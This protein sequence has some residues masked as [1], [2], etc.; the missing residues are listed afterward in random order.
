M[1]G[2]REGGQLAARRERLRVGDH[3]GEL[4]A[5]GAGGQ[6]VT[7]AL[8]LGQRQL[9][10]L[11]LRR[12]Q[13]GGPCTDRRGEHARAPRHARQRRLL[14]RRQQPVAHDPRATVVDLQHLAGVRRPGARQCRREHARGGSEPEHFRPSRSSPEARKVAP[15]GR[16]ARGVEMRLAADLD[17]DRAAGAADVLALGLGEDAELARAEEP[18][19]RP[20]ADLEAPA[21]FATVCAISTRCRRAASGCS[22]AR[23]RSAARSL[24]RKRTETLWR[25]RATFFASV[26]T[27]SAAPTT[28]IGL[29]TSGRCAITTRNCVVTGT[30]STANEKLPAPSV[31]CALPALTKPCVYG[32]GLLWSTT[33]R[34]ALLVPVS[35][36]ASVDGAAG[37]DRVRVRRQRDAER[38]HLGLERA[39]RALGD[40]EPVLRHEPVV[41]RGRGREP[42]D[43]H[44]DGHASRARAGGDRRGVGAE[45]ARGAVAGRSRSSPRCS[46][47]RAR[48]AWRSS[49]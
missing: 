39:P 43:R 14:R 25:W 3:A 47:R 32:N 34:L 44:A 49:A 33:S 26:G 28:T 1:A 36:P 16:V 38:L 48:S 40:A 18:H 4:V 2:T 10:L 42:G 11:A 41:V 27:C 23:R 31:T 12:R 19:A 8:R 17:R 29:V 45:Q 37:R 13:R 20:V 22:R 9:V 7:R 21:S 5:R 15:I 6:R 35:W 24:P 30:E 46:G